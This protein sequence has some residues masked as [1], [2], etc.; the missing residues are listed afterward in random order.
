MPTL[1]RADQEQ[2]EKAKDLIETPPPRELGFVKS[3][4]YGRLKGEHLFPYP[5]PSADEVARTDEV[6][7]KLDA[8]LKAEVDADRIDAEERI[9][10]Q[11]I[12][13][14]GKLG[15][16]GLTVPVEYGGLG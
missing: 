12:D 14:L 8:F 16:L 3:L 5:R 15:V 10:Q 9:P 4:F 11:V 1:K 13:G 7:A 2:F 6:I